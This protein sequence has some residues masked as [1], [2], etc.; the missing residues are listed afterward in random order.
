MN[1]QTKSIEE[2]E[3]VNNL[4]RTIRRLK[5]E[6]DGVN[7]RNDQY[8]A[9]IGFLQ[10][11]IKG[12]TVDKKKTKTEDISRSPELNFFI[13]NTQA[14]LSCIMQENDQLSQ[15]I[16]DLQNRLE[17]SKNEKNLEIENLIKENERLKKEK[18]KTITSFQNFCFGRLKP[19]NLPVKVIS[20]LEYSIHNCL[21]KLYQTMKH[22]IQDIDNSC[23][24]NFNIAI[25]LINTNYIKLVNWLDR[26]PAHRNRIIDC[27]R[28]VRMLRISLSI[29]TSQYQSLAPK[30][31]DLKLLKLA[32]GS[33]VEFERTFFYL[34][35]FPV[36]KNNRDIDRVEKLLL[37]LRTTLSSSCE[38]IKQFHVKTEGF[39]DQDSKEGRLCFM[40]RE[41]RVN[42]ANCLLVLNI[43]VNDEMPILRLHGWFP[44]SL[45]V[46]DGHCLNT[47]H[48]Q[49]LDIFEECNYIND[50]L[51]NTRLSAAP[52]DE[53]CTPETN[54]LVDDYK[55]K[56]YSLQKEKE[57]LEFELKTY[58]VVSQNQTLEPNNAKVFNHLKDHMCQIIDKYYH[59]SQLLSGQISALQADL[60]S[61]LI[62]IRVYDSEKHELSQK[63]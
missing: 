6:I 56:I 14:Q 19:S 51:S 2:K 8:I 37:H 50:K 25:N 9:R 41:C 31:R 27:G 52:E 39:E 26:V 10:N 54:H 4:R 44:G 38:K 32:T 13:E 12:Q 59:E 23:G 28:F 35:R 18:V 16:Y 7:F 55:K 57:T 45:Q 36:S 49:Y 29:C 60:N 34:N 1:I 5:N 11:E 21:I 22:L 53:F 62:R 24:N 47:I 42:L 3:E 40:L 48:S 46:E 20:N 63:T 58:S 30:C 17:E 33:L 15:K 61:A 43:I